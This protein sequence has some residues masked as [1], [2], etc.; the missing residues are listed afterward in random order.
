M[1]RKAVFLDNDCRISLTRDWGDGPRAFVLGCNP[2]NAGADRD[3]PTTHWLNRWFR[4]HGFGGYDL[5]NLYPFITSSP[6]ECRKIVEHAEGGADFSARDALHYVNLPRIR[7]M[8]KSSDQVFVCWGAI[9]WDDFWIDRVVEEIMT[10]CEPWPDL[11]CWGITKGG[12][13]K[14]PMARGLHRIPPDQEPILW[15]GR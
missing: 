5:G 11:W 13:P 15:R 2:S 10:G 7:E 9:A 14:H 3:D 1:K 6:A 8:A 4:R 12:A